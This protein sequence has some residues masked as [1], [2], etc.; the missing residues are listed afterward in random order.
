MPDCSK[1]F[2]ALCAVLTLTGGCR[3][4]CLVNLNTPQCDVRYPRSTLSVHSISR[5]PS[6]TEDI[7]VDLDSNFTISGTE[8]VGRRWSLTPFDE[9]W[10]IGM[11][12]VNTVLAV[13]PAH[14][15]DG[16]STCDN[17]WRIEQLDSDENTIRFSPDGDTACQ[18]TAAVSLWQGEGSFGQ[19]VAATDVDGDGMLDLWVGAPD[20]NLQQGSLHLFLNPAENQTPDLTLMG[21][22]SGEQIGNNLAV[23]GDVNGDGIGDTLVGTPYLHQ[24]TARSNPRGSGGAVLLQSGQLGDLSEEQTLFTAER[25]WTGEGTS[26]HAGLALWCG[27]DLTGDMY[28]DLLISAPFSNQCANTQEGVQCGAVY[29]IPGGPNVLQTG[30]LASHSIRTF[31]GQ[32]D[33]GFCGSSVTA[34]DINNDGKPEILIGC[35]GANGG[36]GRVDIYEGQDLLNANQ[37]PAVTLTGNA[38]STSQAH[39]GALLHLADVRGTGFQGLFAGAPYQPAANDSIQSGQIFFWSNANLRQALAESTSPDATYLYQGTN[40]FESVGKKFLPVPRSDSP[41]QDLIIFTRNQ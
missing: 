26:E 38:S 21:T 13:P 22:N 17:W 23:C 27:S 30:T 12:L 20:T 31:T 19:T 37:G 9:G 11:P 15:P 2:A 4:E 1:S 29:L 14:G 3:G 34:G 41:A 25:G 5:I 32:T 18:N 16:L 10:A 24:T 39:L 7:F 36:N 28:A 8:S 33:R 35:P 6:S 40:P